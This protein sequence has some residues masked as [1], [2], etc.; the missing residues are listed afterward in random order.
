MEINN[1]DLLRFT[2]KKAVSGE[3]ETQ[4]REIDIAEV[5]ARSCVDWQINETVEDELNINGKTV[6]MFGTVSDSELESIYSNSQASNLA[7]VQVRVFNDETEPTVEPT[8][9]PVTDPTGEP[10]T[11]PTQ[12]E[13]EVIQAL[14]E[15]YHPKISFTSGYGFNDTESLFRWLDNNKFPGAKENGYITKAQL[16]SLTQNDAKEDACSDFFGILNRAFSEKG[17]N[18]KITQAE[19]NNLII[20]SAGDDNSCTAAE[21]KVKV[22]RYAEKVQRDFAACNTDQKKMDFILQKTREYLQAAGLTLQEQ[23]MDRLLQ[24]TD[25]YNSSS[26]V[27]K[28]QIVFASFPPNEDGSITLGTYQPTLAYTY[29]GQHYYS[30]ANNQT[31][32]TQ[33]WA[34]DAD[35]SELDGG[36]TLNTIYLDTTQTKWYEAVDTLVHELTHATAYYYYNVTKNTNGDVTNI[37]PSIAGLDYMKQVGA[38]TNAEYDRFAGYA[39][40]TVNDLSEEELGRLE[41]LLISMWGEYRAYQTDADYVDSIGGDVFDAGNL[42][43]AVSG[44]QEKSTIEQHVNRFYD[45]NGNPVDENGNPT[46]EFN[47]RPDW[48]WWTA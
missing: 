26:A 47:P 4:N 2:S 40:G 32:W 23:A 10:T 18:D 24:G 13:S 34:G 43:T 30:S 6:N 33:L 17:P 19:I 9:E 31:Y 11:E 22:L 37:L 1:A 39:N 21:L 48:H 16:T 28:G 45:N 36:L 5:N 12:S 7:P 25:T 35:T 29:C 42:T 15:Y 14:Y 41:Y 8:T 27:K 44:S 46:D 38:I 3:E 20:K